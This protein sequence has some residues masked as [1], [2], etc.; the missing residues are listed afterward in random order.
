MDSNE[1]IDTDNLFGTYGHSFP[2]YDTMVN[3][4]DKTLY[5]LVIGVSEFLRKL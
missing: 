4:G 5:I 1:K 3:D 2:T